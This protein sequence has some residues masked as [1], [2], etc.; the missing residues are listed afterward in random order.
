MSIPAARLALVLAG[1]LTIAASG[2]TS[3]SSARPDEL[4][5]PV[6]EGLVAEMEAA[7]DLAAEAHATHADR[8]ER[9][10]DPKRAA[11]TPRSSAPADRQG[12]GF[13]AVPRW[14]FDFSDVQRDSAKNLGGA[15]RRAAVGQDR[16]FLPNAV[17]RAAVFETSTG[18]QET[19]C[20]DKDE[21][22]A[23]R[24]EHEWNRRQREADRREARAR[25]EIARQERAEARR[26][27]E[28][29][30]MEAQA[31]REMVRAGRHMER[32][33]ESHAAN[34]ER[35]MAPLTTRM[36]TPGFELESR[37]EERN[38]QRYRGS[39]PQVM[40]EPPPTITI[41]F[42]IEDPAGSGSDAGSKQLFAKGPQ[43][44]PADYYVV[45]KQFPVS[46]GRAN[47]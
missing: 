21:M 11:L 24:N 28:I 22:I 8:A 45:T 39:R 16:D 15:F 1:F 19:E 34:F 10:V 5:G 37:T 7:E 25:R 36:T 42:H 33:G 9:G 14:T 44:R 35:E 27:R 18:E 17:I 12:W 38:K 20:E 47:P 40:P 29:A 31:E 43:R 46:A 26:E 3:F 30:R 6:G 2:D 23:D 32:M 4:T 13:E 41:S